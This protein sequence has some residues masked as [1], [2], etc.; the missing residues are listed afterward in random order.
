[1]GSNERERDFTAYAESNYP[2]MIIPEMFNNSQDIGDGFPGL[3]GAVRN[4]VTWWLHSGNMDSGLNIVG[5]DI[6]G[7]NLLYVDNI[8]GEIDHYGN[9]SGGAN[10]SISGYDTVNAR[11][12]L[13]TQLGGAS[14]INMQDNILFNNIYN[15][16]GVNQITG[17]NALITNAKITNAVQ[18]IDFGG[19]YTLTNLQSG[20]A[21]GEP[22][23]Y[24][25]YQ[26]FESNYYTT[27]GDY[28]EMSG[29]YVAHAISNG[30]SHTYINQSVIS[31]ASPTFNGLNMNGNVDM[32]QNDVIDVDNI[33]NTT[34][35][36]NITAQTSLYLGAGGAA[37]V[38]V[39]QAL[40]QALVSA[41][42]NI[43][44]TV[45]PITHIYHCGITAQT[46]A[47]FSHLE[48]EKLYE[49]LS[50]I[51]PRNDIFEELKNGELYPHIDMSTVHDVFAD[52]APEDFTRDLEKLKD[53]NGN[54][55]TIDYKKGDKVG[56][57]FENYVL[58]LKE[59]VLRSYE[60]IVYLKQ[61]IENLKNN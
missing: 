48:D 42:K 30:S 27:S 1:M 56:F 60:T 37:S 9:L 39:I 11:T 50:S 10:F 40:D 52:I 20:N 49:I 46:C 18:N 61:E 43:G 12:G 45:V 28:V 47:D 23:R 29:A 53:K 54:K 31:T 44:T 7:V 5:F 21:N 26:P 36:M 25:E 14:D 55:T 2:G 41:N 58:A 35:S 6:T 17:I 57:D 32:N 16:Q 22:I 13:F 3:Q 38:W 34:S 15:V 4:W 24:D 33:T 51:K 8:T 19:S 59:M